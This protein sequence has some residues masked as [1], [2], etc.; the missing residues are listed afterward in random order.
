MGGMGLKMGSQSFVAQPMSRR[1]IRNL[2]NFFRKELGLTNE[3]YFPVIQVLEWGLAIIDEDFQYEIQDMH[4]MGTR[5]GLTYP[6]Q[7]KIIIREDVYENAI[8]GLGR[9]RLTIAHEIGHYLMHDTKNLALAR[10][11]N[12]QKIAAYLDPEWQANAFAGELLAPPHIIRGMTPFRIS[13]ECGL[14]MQAAEM[15]LKHSRM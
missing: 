15:Q 8:N 6:D 14:S 5:H 10:T 4:E 11:G 9:D 1:N 7:S 12:G 3:K 2:A 13:R